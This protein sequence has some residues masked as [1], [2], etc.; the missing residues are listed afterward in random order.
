VI[1][2][3]RVVRAAAT[4]VGSI[5]VVLALGG[6]S[7]VSAQPRERTPI[8]EAAIP[9]VAAGAAM[10][11]A[12]LVVS[13]L[14]DHSPGASASTWRGGILLDEGVRNGLRLHS[15]GDRDTAAAISDALM[16][17]TM[18][19][20][21]AVDGI[22]IPL[23]QD[24]PH[25]SWQASTAYSLALGITLVLGDVVKDVVGR[26]RPFER[27]CA[28]DPSAEGCSNPDTYAS[29]YSLHT[30]V[31]FTGAG[32]SCAMH[33]SRSLYDDPLADAATCGA[34]LA[35]AAATGLLRIASDRHYFSDVLVGAVLGFLV[36]YI[37]PLMFIPE[38]RPAV[39]EASSIDEDDTG[40][41]AP[42]EGASAVVVPMYSPG[43]DGLS[44][45]TFG[46]S[47]SGTF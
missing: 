21:V 44:S 11:G 23:A 24:D 30:A 39:A 18:L 28:Q 35:V 31:A 2:T 27:E 12:G 8:S 5:I 29:F 42:V 13:L 40:I 16:V 14:A 37:V 10:I 22:A 26:A 33:L 43:S 7:P 46:L 25:L 38:R 1:R 3:Q 45:G 19:N 36:G 6:P 17:A 32:F 9:T 15:A 4:V 47:V 20:A 34:S 41:A